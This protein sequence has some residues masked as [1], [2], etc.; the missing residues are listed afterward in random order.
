[1]ARRSREG[2]TA[3]RRALLAAI[4]RREGLLSMMTLAAAGCRRADDRAYA[5]GGM[6]M[7]SESGGSSRRLDT[8]RTTQSVAK[9]SGPA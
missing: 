6:R 8:C 1:M 7:M 9:V 4:A 2:L 3:Q 5:R